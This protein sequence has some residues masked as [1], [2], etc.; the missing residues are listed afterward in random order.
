LVPNIHGRVLAACVAAMSIGIA[1]SAQQANPSAR[2]QAVIRLKGAEFAPGRG[3]EPRI[4]PGLTIAGY[5]AGERG[6]F[7][8]QFDGPILETWKADVAATGAELLDYIP[9]FAFK[10]R[11]NPAQAAQLARLDSVVWVGLFHPAYKIDRD[12]IRGGVRPYTVRIEQGAD[13][14]A[15]AAMITATGAQVLGREGSIVTVSADSAQLDAIAHVLDVASVENIL[16]RKKNNEY[17]AGVIIGAATANA[18]GFDGSTQTVGIA[19]TGLG[20]GTAAGAFIDI[21]S[22]R[23]SAIFNWPGAAG[24]CFASVINDGAVDVDSGHGTHTTTSI[25]GAGG[26]T[27]VGRGSAPS[28]HLIFQ[29]VENWATI[30]SLCRTFYGYQDGY[31][32]AGIPSD[33]RQLFQQAYDGGARI[34]SNSWGSDAAGAYT[35]D[36]VNADQFVWSHRDMTVTFSAGNSGTDANADGVIDLRSIGSPATAKN[37]ISVG[38]S[39]NDRQGHWECD[40]ALTYTSCAAQAGKNQIF[41]YGSAW[42]SDYPANPIKNDPSANNSQQ[43]AAFSSRG[44]SSD[45]RIKPDVVAPGTWILSGYSDMYQQQYDPSGNPRNG[46][47]QYD[48]WGYPLNG[49][50]KYM[51]GTSMANPIVAG[52][53]AVIRDFYQKTSGH[54]ASAALVKATLVNS[55]VD[56]LDENNDGLNDNANPIPNMHEGWGLV[57]LAAATAGGRQFIDGTTSLITTGTATYNF[58][59][60]S[61]GS[62]LKATLA[63][64]DYPSTT[65]AAK[66]L[67]N[68]LDLVVTAPDGTTYLG[69]VFAGGWSQPNGT[70]DRTNNLENVFVAGA[71][72]GTWTI[73]VRGYNIPSGPQPFALIV[74]AAFGA[75]PPPV[76]PSPPV[77]LIATAA[78]SSRIDLTWTDASDNEDGFQIE[79]CETA[80]CTTFAP[81]GQ[82]GPNVAAFSD[83][84]LAAGTTYNYRVRAFNTGGQ[85][86]YSNTAAATTSSAAQPPAAPS[87]LV[88]TAVSASQINLSWADNSS[89]ESGFEIDRCQGAGCLNFATIAQPAANVVSYAD[90]GRPAGT[91]FSYRVRAVNA[92]GGSGYSNTASATTQARSHVGDLD[93]ST[94]TTGQNWRATISIVVHNDGHVLVSGATVSGTWSGAES[95]VASCTTNA[96][97]VCTV[98][99]GQ[100][101][102][103][104]QPNVTFTVGN[105][106]HSTLAYNAASNH[107]PDGDSNG[108]TINVL[109]P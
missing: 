96:V 59:V 102:R 28:A 42:P 74:D 105:I 38:A 103:N 89:D 109:K 101:K 29:A 88:A 64:S 43:M 90:T 54:S 46:A 30:T 82:V 50:Y 39:E 25:L 26:P 2:G 80:G 106:S 4:P 52:G 16:I 17:G 71:A 7:I 66:N 77:G 93:G 72:A 35:S 19:D 56:L 36:S 45:G 58:T 14:A 104:T 107:D 99:T 18:H 41:T 5:A 69:N 65:A 37:V 94:T 62:P 75:P 15:A 40:T 108:T 92:A 22:S 27:G 86:D 100:L 3:E 98:T 78:S 33:I 81:A 48:G 70:A 85:S 87:N 1:L 67:V 51:G 12:V 11:M 97:G 95:G 34:H 23:I 44:P 24:G 57:N 73:S 49:S 20:N 47:Y 8:V 10:V 76:P 55:A 13:A 84:G 6:Y 68:D 32:L 53:A 61:A 83:S 9:D 31:Y 63:W 60:A 79:R 91:T 21:P